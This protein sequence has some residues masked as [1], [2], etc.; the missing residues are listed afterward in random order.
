MTHNTLVG[1]V[2]KLPDI[3]VLCVGDVMLDRFVGGAVRRISPESPVPVLSMT[4]TTVFAGGAANVAQNIAAL[5]GRCTLIGVVGEDAA[6]REMEEALARSPGITPLLVTSTD[7]PTTEKTRFV[8]QGQ[9]I[10]R[11]DN[12]VA[13]PVPAATEDIL[14]A[15]IRGQIAAHAVLLL[16][17]YAKGVLTDRVVTEAIALA[18]T[19]GVPVVVDPKSSTFTRYDGATILTPNAAEAQAASGIDPREDGGAA[20]AARHLLESTRID[21]VLITRAERGMTL[22]ERGGE[23][24]HVPSRARQVADVVGA[25]DTVIATLALGI[26][27][28]GG[29]AEAAALANA[30]A[31][32]VVGKRG[33]ATVSRAELISELQASSRPGP[34]STAGKQQDRG[35]A[36]AA[37]E[38]WRRDGLKVGF[39]NGCFDLLHAGHVA[40]IEYARAHCDRLVVGVNADASVRRLKGPTRP[41][42]TEIDRARVLA[43]LAAVDAV[44]IFEEDTPAELIAYLAPD[45]LV[46]GSDYQIEQIVGADTV[47][48]RGGEV[49]RFDLLAGHSTTSTIARM[50][51]QDS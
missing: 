41:V 9:H 42:N 40:I 3:A 35:V 39:T 5:G 48:A 4:G 32:I 15:A 50:Q 24:R 36:L 49:L 46:K 8:A 47:L 28:G 2:T 11:A 22:L 25:G 19:A 12:E 30:A 17:D 10:L 27:A 51:E 34:V 14:I 1:L 21:A 43:A 7:R 16:S 23:A 44:V 33:T 6:A 18:R 20:L 38:A 13:R 29:L 45:V 26:G 37:V 31:G